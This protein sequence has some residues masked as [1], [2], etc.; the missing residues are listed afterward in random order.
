MLSHPFDDY[1]NNMPMAN[2]I[3]D[4]AVVVVHY[5]SRLISTYHGIQV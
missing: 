3:S 5:G 2:L 4:M 1:S